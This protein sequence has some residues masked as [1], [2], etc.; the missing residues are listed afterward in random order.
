[1]SEKGVGIPTLSISLIFLETSNCHRLYFQKTHV[2]VPTYFNNTWPKLFSDLTA[3]CV[4][5][6]GHICL[7]ALQ[8][9]LFVCFSD[10]P[11]TAWEAFLEGTAEVTILADGEVASP[12]ESTVY[13]IALEEPLVQALVNINDDGAYALL[14]D[15][16]SDEVSVVATS[17][18]GVV[19]TAG[20]VE[21]VEE[22]GDHDDGE[23]DK[24]S[25][26]TAQQWINA[27]VA[28]LVVSFC[29]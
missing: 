8:L 1:M 27:I 18:T 15:H 9:F 3:F 24:S 22:D 23:E 5:Y 13:S 14:V 6:R 16:A 29:R 2:S 26:A 21:G 10:I 20:T 4:W 17:S 11:L 25:S 19:L 28:S 12:S 7:F